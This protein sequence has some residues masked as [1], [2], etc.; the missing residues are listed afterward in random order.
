MLIHLKVG[1]TLDSSLS[2][3]SFL[4]LLSGLGLFLYGMHVM[5]G[6]LEKIAGSKLER[7][8][9]R[10]TSSKFKGVLLG[11]AVT[12]VIQS[13][14]ATTVMV[15]GF[16]NAGI[17]KLSQAVSVIMGANIGTTVTAQ[18]L[19]L[20]DISS[21]NILLQLIK[22]SGFSHI[23]LLIGA[24]IALFS[25]KKKRQDIGSLLLGLGMLFF[26]M[27]TMESALSPLRELEGFKA[28]FASFSNPFLGILIG[29]GVTAVIQSS[30]ASV[31][32]LQALSTTGVV[33]FSSMVPI[34]LGQ[35]IGTCI[36]VILASIGASKNAKRAAMVHLTFNFIG[37]VAFAIVIYGANAIVDIPFWDKVM[38]MGD[39][40]NF[41]TVF[42][43]VNTLWM[44]P[45]SGILVKIAQALVKDGKKTDEFEALL[46]ERFLLTPV[47][48]LEQSRKMLSAMG[49]YALENVRLAC[50][51]HI[52]LEES[53]IA[54]INEN[55]AICDK[56]ESS[57]TSYLIKLSST[58]LSEEDHWLATQMIPTLTD[59]ERVSDRAVNIVEV[60]EYNQA[61]GIAFSEEGLRELSVISDAVVDILALTTSSYAEM[62][63]AKAIRIEPL[64]E[65]VDRLTETL[66]ERHISRLQQGKCT[67]E[68]GI[69]F[70]EILTNLERIADH[71]SNIGIRIMQTVDHNPDVMERHSYIRQLH[72]N[73]SREYDEYF[74]EY[75]QLYFDRL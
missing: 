41:H 49:G 15:V 11:T 3:L 27:L 5:G 50:Q 46:D 73:G 56:T 47:V 68:A 25:M 13:S 38:N 2:I 33:T 31:G 6:S 72:E 29:T 67:V 18:I 65:I 7:T 75:K 60:A 63:T 43:V 74:S 62:D 55:E 66:R 48:A 44:L 17:M 4:P 8:L 71:C 1:D 37:T 23:F 61:H 54:T 30:S 70:I 45:L 36:T 53:A 58:D 24:F 69:S 40:A 59:Y 16:V 51:Q 19:R 10:L 34:V 52:K 32:I 28:A 39:I 12:A 57:L 22:P 20:G 35:N 21:D 64:E 42:N 9:D 14:S 26:G